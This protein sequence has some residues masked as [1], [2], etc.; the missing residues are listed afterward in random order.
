LADNLAKLVQ[1]MHFDGINIDIEYVAPESRLAFTQFVKVVADRLHQDGI[2]VSISVPAK[3]WDDPANGWAGGYDYQA[4]GNLVDRMMLM[5]YD[6]H[7]YSTGDGPVASSGWVRNVVR[8]AVGQVP[9]YKLLVGLPAYGFDWTSSKSYP[10][11]LDYKQAMTPVQNK[12]ATLQWDAT[13]NV[14]KYAY[15]DAAGATHKVWF[16]N[17]SSSTWKLD[18]VKEFGLRGFSLWRAGM[19]DPALWSVVGQKM[20]AEK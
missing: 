10:V 2:R 14:P 5:T 16:E 4:L 11:Y 8:Y 12:M 3:T 19:E 9:G 18:L 15:T 6:E 17:A 1:R 20:R 13:A 7:G